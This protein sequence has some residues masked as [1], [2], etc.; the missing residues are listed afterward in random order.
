LLVFDWVIM[1]PASYCLAVSIATCNVAGAVVY[2]IGAMVGLSPVK[3]CH[4][5]LAIGILSVV[6]VFRYNF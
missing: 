3:N 5:T 4:T 2:T 6:S 1:N